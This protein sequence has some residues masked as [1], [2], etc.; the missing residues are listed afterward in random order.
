MNTK[1]KP[2]TADAET[3]RMSELARHAI[4]DTPPEDRFERI[5][6]LARVLFDAPGCAISLIDTDR[7]W[8]KARSGMGIGLEGAREFSFCNHAIRGNSVFIVPDARQDD[9][10]SGNPLVEGPPHI[11]FYAGAP[12]RSENGSNLGALCIL[13]TEPRAEFS[14]ADQ[15][16]LEAL[17]GVV[18][19]EMEL[20]Y[21]S[22]HRDETA[23]DRELEIK[24]Q[25]Q[26]AYYRIRNK[27]EY[28]ALIAEIQAGDLPLEKLSALAVAAWE[29]HLE[30]DGV[31]ANSIRSLRRLMTPAQYK[32]LLKSMPG[33]TI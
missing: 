27:L 18:V 1:P 11:R 20:R 32:E 16:R 21:Q 6:A 4:L 5:V 13:S 14:E 12:L 31:L 7:Q 9:R 15:K 17:A 33:F 8:H 24:S 3:L 29:Q 10:F 30:A 2:S 23:H 25:L 28:T 19:N 26:E 22:K